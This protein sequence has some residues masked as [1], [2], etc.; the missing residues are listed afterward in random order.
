MLSPPIYTIQLPVYEGPLD[1]LLNLIEHAELDITKVSLAEVTDQYLVY[2]R[3]IQDRQLEDL[4]SFLVMAARLIQIKSE[5]LLPRPPL[6]EPGE[7]DPGDALARQ[8][9]AYKKYKQVAILLSEREESGLRSYIR[10]APPPVIDPKI[11]MQ[12]FQL[13]DLYQAMLEVLK[14]VHKIPTLEE[15]ISTLRVSVRDKILN[16]IHSLKDVSQLSFRKLIQTA[17]SRLEIVVSL[18]AIL[19]LIKQD[20]VE[21]RQEEMFGDIELVRGSGWQVDQIEELEFEFDE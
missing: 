2:I 12:E 17:R 11:D 16:I 4:A 21:V 9:V 15:N 5:V 3:Q 20:Q 6:R 10:L 8:L 13:D 1:L 7:E 18:L 14:N 19:E